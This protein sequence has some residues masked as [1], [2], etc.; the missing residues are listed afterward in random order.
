MSTIFAPTVSAVRS[1]LKAARP[2]DTVEFD[3][4]LRGL[5]KITDI[6]G[7]EGAPITLR[8]KNRATARILG[9]G[10]AEAN[11]RFERCEFF[12]FGN[13]VVADATGPEARGVQAFFCKGVRFF[14]IATTN[15]ALDHVHA[16]MSSHLVFDTLTA[17]GTSGKMGRGGQI[18]PHAIYVTADEF[19][20]EDF[21]LLN[22]YARDILGACFQA[23]GDG[24]WIRKFRAE[25]C[26]AID[27]QKSAGFNLAFVDGAHLEGCV[28]RS[29]HKVYGINAYDGTKRV[30]AVDCLIDV[31]N[32]TAFAGPIVLRGAP[33]VPAPPPAVCPTCK[34]P[35]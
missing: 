7:Q 31:P 10:K 27:W 14:N 12:Q 33:P 20:V 32:G 22:C 16:A 17:D 26:E 15:I 30:E 21:L 2:G 4:D 13:C 19:D 35:L 23:N 11:V 3:G 1:A 29:R 9:T 28:I 8:G 25:G 34:R 18:G 5:G 24:K 6:K